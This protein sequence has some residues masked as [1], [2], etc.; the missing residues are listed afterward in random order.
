MGVRVLRLLFFLLVVRPLALI[1][2]GLN[3]RHRERLPASGP[4]IVVAN[5]NSHLDTLVL[6]SLFPLAL[7]PKLHPVAAA[8]YF[9]RNRIVAWFALN[10]IGIV[11]IKR[12]AMGVE[13]P[14]AAASQAIAQGDILIL[15]PEGSRGEPERLAEF[16]SGVAHLAKRHAA[17]PVVPVFLHGLGK[18]LPK[19]EALLVPFFCDVFLGLPLYW[20]GD[21]HSF[22]STLEAQINALS[23]EGNFAPWE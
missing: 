21:K 18:A 13:D 16:K 15:F 17:V 1:V 22:L 12:R 7:L 3:V 5:H 2:I 19:G 23:A 11:P 10:I 14:L 4:A 20:G 9:L 8:D 6:M